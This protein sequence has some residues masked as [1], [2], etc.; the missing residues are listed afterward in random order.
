LTGVFVIMNKDI[1]IVKAKLDA[2]KKEYNMLRSE[3]IEAY[4]ADGSTPLGVSIRDE[5][6]YR[7]LSDDII[8]ENKYYTVNNPSKNINCIS[9]NI[10]C[11]S[12]VVDKFNKHESMFVNIPL[13]E[14]TI[15]YLS[16]KEYKYALC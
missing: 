15:Q 1:T 8:Y 3:I 7:P 16:V 6:R 12:R 11:I 4:K 5:I 14:Y 2:L 13:E 9:K 10:N